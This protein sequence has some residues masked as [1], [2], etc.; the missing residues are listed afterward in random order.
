M[1]HEK[2]YKL[3]RIIYFIIALFCSQDEQNSE[4]AKFDVTQVDQSDSKSD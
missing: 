3:Y 2:L 4:R 1:Q